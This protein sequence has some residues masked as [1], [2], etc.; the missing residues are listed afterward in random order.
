MVLVSCPVCSTRVSSLSP[1]CSRCGYSFV[2]GEAGRSPEAAA[3]A[4]IPLPLPAYAAPAAHGEMP[5]WASQAQAVALHP[6]SVGKLAVMS[7]FT[8]GLYQLYWCYRNWYLLKA[9]RRED[10]S[11]FWRAFFAP[12]FGFSLFR[13]VRNEAERNGVPVGWSAGGMGLLF[14]VLAGLNRLPDPY[15]L[16]TLLM[17]VPLLPVQATINELNARSRQPAPVNEKYSAIN[18]LGIGVGGLFLA[19][20]AIAL[21]FPAE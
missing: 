6:M 1:A 17:F 21:A 5:L 4:A 18:L 3:A 7:L 15:W 9:F 14:F 11:P 13:N 16:V 20:V 12:L 8:F 2:A 10:V 19:L